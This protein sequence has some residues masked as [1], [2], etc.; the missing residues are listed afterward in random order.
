MLGSFGGGGENYRYV[1]E[2]AGIFSQATS[3]IIAQ[4][5]TRTS[6]RWVVIK[7]SLL[8]AYWEHSLAKMKHLNFIP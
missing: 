2:F 5:I 6:Y 8:L 4:A 7:E 1:K 3:Y